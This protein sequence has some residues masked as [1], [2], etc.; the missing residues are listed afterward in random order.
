MVEIL[1]EKPVYTRHHARNALNSAP[2]VTDINTARKIT[3]EKIIPD[4]ELRVR[5]IFFDNRKY[6]IL[7]YPFLSN[8]VQR[9]KFIESRAQM[10]V[11]CNSGKFKVIPDLNSNNRP[12]SDD[13]CKNCGNFEPSDRY[14]TGFGCNII[15]RTSQV[16]H[17]LKDP[18][19]KI[20]DADISPE[21][22]FNSA[23]NLRVADVVSYKFLE[24][25][26]PFIKITN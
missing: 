2:G 11:A 14:P 18:S 21:V 20:T 4:F 13:H 24:P 23:K 22:V 1:K 25:S 8:T 17:H 15:R 26:G 5:M 3:R 6:P 10:V 12:N 19:Q 16:L 9:E 7:M